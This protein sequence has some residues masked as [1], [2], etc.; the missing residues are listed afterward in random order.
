MEKATLTKFCSGPHCF[1]LNFGPSL[2]KTS[3]VLL[4]RKIKKMH[5]DTAKI[6][7]VVV[8]PETNSEGRKVYS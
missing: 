1:L 2:M 8:V 4:N 5:Y 7:Q 6:L 3:I